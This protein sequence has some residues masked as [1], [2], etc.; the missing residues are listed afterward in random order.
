MAAFTDATVSRWMKAF[1]AGGFPWAIVAGGA[2]RD[3]GPRKTKLPMKSANKAARTPTVRTRTT[4]RAAAPR[5][6]SPATTMANI[7]NLDL[8]VNPSNKFVRNLKTV[9]ELQ[10]AE[11]FDERPRTLSRLRGA[12]RRPRPR[13]HPARPQR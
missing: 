12:S 11:E 2:A 6:A 1:W 4:R 5:F 9:G 8:L 3:P 7:T 13:R 10:P